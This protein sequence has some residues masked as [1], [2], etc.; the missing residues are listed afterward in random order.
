MKIM[1]NKNIDF[2]FKKNID[3]LTKAYFIFKGKKTF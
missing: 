1:L 3:L 2:I